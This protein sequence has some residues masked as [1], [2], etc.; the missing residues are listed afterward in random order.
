MKDSN[1]Y[2][3]E[4]FGA[5]YTE[6]DLFNTGLKVA[7]AVQAWYMSGNMSK[8]PY[9]L[10]SEELVAKIIYGEELPEIE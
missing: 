8:S 5:Q 7:E 6:N 9:G 10:S 2:D 1:D 3:E 4:V